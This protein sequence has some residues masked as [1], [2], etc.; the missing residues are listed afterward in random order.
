MH[1]VTS[2]AFVVPPPLPSS[3][4]PSSSPQSSPPARWTCRRPL[5]RKRRPKPPAPRPTR[6]LPSLPTAIN[7]S[8]SAPL[9]AP[10][11]EKCPQAAALRSALSARRDA[12]VVGPGLRS[13]VAT[14]LA[15]RERAEHALVVVPT[16]DAALRAA[17]E[18]ALRGGFK[19]IVA[20]SDGYASW[21]R[22]AMNANSSKRA[23]IV[24]TTP[25]GAVKHFVNSGHGVPWLR[26]VRFLLVVDAA[27]LLSIGAANLFGNVIK[28][29]P[30]KSRRKTVVIE[31]RPLQQ[32]A[33]RS[34]Q[35]ILDLLRPNY[36]LV[37]W[38]VPD[39]LHTHAM[40]K[41]E[42]V[43]QLDLSSV[44]QK[45]HTACAKQRLEHLVHLCSDVYRSSQPCKMIVFFPTARII[46]CYA[47]LCRQRGISIV[48]IHS[49]TSVANR[50][51]GLQALFDS[52]RIV[53]FA[54]D[55]LALCP[56]LPHVDTVVHVGLPSHRHNYLRRVALLTK[57][58]SESPQS[59]SVMLLS[60]DEY[61][62][63]VNSHTG[64]ALQLQRQQCPSSHILAHP[65]ID[66][67]AAVD[68]KARRKAY[69]SWLCFHNT[70]RNRM[71]WSKERMV[72]VANDWALNTFGHV[73]VL[74]KKDSSRVKLWKV[75]GL[76]VEQSA[77]RT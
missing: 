15:A 19:V 12:L 50:E 10:A 77:V 56:T 61:A 45:A 11:P 6:P 44:L 25:R 75:P 34:A 26:K 66:A 30:H 70:V 40:N 72:Q 68:E 2:A 69:V 28:R 5:H 53:V 7:R 31:F 35:F 24:V 39:Q 62:F 16:R 48:D 43:E 1:A 9:I 8:Y 17:E 46:E 73:P 37:E 41:H 51:R 27:S 60:D 58:A 64:L 4:S 49:N 54:S 74:T 20:V 59:Q 32:C 52:Q 18:A 33:P 29:L 38:T 3:S 65:H 23:V 57:N 42:L 36:Q 71:G 67:H 47:S 55:T 21:K 22:A 63:A 13:K 14:A 76:Q